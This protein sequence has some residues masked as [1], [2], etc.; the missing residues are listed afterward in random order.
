MTGD[1]ERQKVKEEAKTL[2][3]VEKKALDQN[4]V[5]NADEVKKVTQSFD[6]IAASASPEEAKK[7]RAMTE[8]VTSYRSKLEAF[9]SLGGAKVET[10][11]SREDLDNRIAMVDDLTA[12]SKQVEA[13]CAANDPDPANLRTLDLEQQLLGK[14]RQQLMFYKAHYGKWQTSP[15][16]PTRFAVSPAELAQFNSVAADIKSLGAQ[17]MQLMKKNTEERLGKLKNSQ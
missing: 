8:S 12:K 10:L 3:N 2:Y 14:I 16:G 7:L 17:Q 1:T 15:S 9:K 6:K 11:K 5:L 13:A 4:R